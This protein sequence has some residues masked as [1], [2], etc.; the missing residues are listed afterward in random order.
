M[1][2]TYDLLDIARA[3][4]T[5]AGGRDKVVAALKNLGLTRVSECPENKRVALKKA[6]EQL[7]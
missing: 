4:M 2:T 7:P 1:V 3:K 6:L 5:K